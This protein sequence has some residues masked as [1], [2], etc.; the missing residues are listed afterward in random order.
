VN[1]KHKGIAREFHAGTH[2]FDGLV[3]RVAAFGRKV[4]SG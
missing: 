3:G 4:R 2:Q 1:A